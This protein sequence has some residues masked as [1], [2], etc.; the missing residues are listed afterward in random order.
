LDGIVLAVPHKMYLEPEFQDLGWRFRSQGVLVD[1]RSIYQ[2][3]V[4]EGV[5]YWSL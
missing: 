2:R 5:S 1:I 3:S 4:P